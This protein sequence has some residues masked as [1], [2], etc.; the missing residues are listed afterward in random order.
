MAMRSTT[1]GTEI[2][3]PAFPIGAHAGARA[4]NDNRD[5]ISS[6]DAT[7]LV[8]RKQD[9]VTVTISP[10]IASILETM[11]H[12]QDREYGGVMSFNKDGF[13]DAMTVIQGEEFSIP[14]Q[15]HPSVA[16]SYHTHPRNPPDVLHQPPSTNDVIT[17]LQSG[18]IHMELLF[19]EEG[20]YVIDP[21]SY[22][23]KNGL[24]AFLKSLKRHE[25]ELFNFFRVNQYD[26]TV[27][28][29]A[30]ME[31]GILDLSN[32]ATWTTY[33]SWWATMGVI[34]HLLSYDEACQFKFRVSSTP[35]TLADGF[36]VVPD[37]RGTAASSM[38][39][40]RLMQKNPHE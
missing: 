18:F 12:Q 9:V 33:K 40:Y 21:A 30:L 36:P 14:L 24:R 19:T 4:G 17:Y 37:I 6:R 26:P 27:L 35:I 2:F 25:P 5:I 3:I 34:I 38:Y 15:L 23:D 22:S 7:T 1:A 10:G 32:L 16:V 29:E 20:V 11:C 28:M 39:S 8:H 13:L 31:N